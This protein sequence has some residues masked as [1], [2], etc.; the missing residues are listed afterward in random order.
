MIAATAC[1]RESNHKTIFLKKSCLF[2][3]HYYYFYCE[4]RKEPSIATASALLFSLHDVQC[5]D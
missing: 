5:C 4:E 3:K 2:V 1:V